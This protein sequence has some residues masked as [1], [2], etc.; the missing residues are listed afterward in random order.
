MGIRLAGM[1]PVLNDEQRGKIDD[2][3]VVWLTTVG[4]D[5]APMPTPVWTVAEG[6]AFVI[7]SDPAAAKVRNAR[8]SPKATLNLNTDERGGAV[9]VVTG[10]LEV[11]EDAEPPL[12]IDR[13]RE[14]YAATVPA[15]GQ[16]LEEF[17]AMYRTRLTFTPTKVRSF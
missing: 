15:L 11:V 8:R 12:S 3:T 16:T 2:A 7:Y 1:E 10:T 14:K 4:A 5:S 6:G 13:Y 9:M 17:D